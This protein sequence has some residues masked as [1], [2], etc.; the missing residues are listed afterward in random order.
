MERCNSIF[1][2]VHSY[3]NKIMQAT[4]DEDSMPQR[5]AGQLPSMQKKK[6]SI[7]SN[8]SQSQASL[9]PQSKG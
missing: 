2:D 9:K 1:M 3:K 6:R 4:E 8:G 5:Q 7:W